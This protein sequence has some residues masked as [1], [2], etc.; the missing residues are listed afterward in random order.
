ML[1]EFDSPQRCTGLSSK[2]SS[3]HKSE[4]SRLEP[5]I[6]FFS[7]LGRTLGSAPAPAY[8]LPDVPFHQ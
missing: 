6:I 5:G 2:T 3:V 8:L 1:F 7:P 4:K